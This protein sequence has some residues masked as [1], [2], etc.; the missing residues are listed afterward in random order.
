MPRTT[1]SGLPTSPPAFPA[2]TALP[3]FPSIRSRFVTKPD[4]NTYS[5]WL[6]ECAAD[7]MPNLMVFAGYYEGGRASHLSPVSAEPTRAAGRSDVCHTCH[8][9]FVVIPLAA[10]LA[11]VV[12]QA[13]A[14][15]RHRQQAQQQGGRDVE[16]AQHGDNKRLLDSMQGIARPSGSSEL[17]ERAA[18]CRQRR[19]AALLS[20]KSLHSRGINMVPLHALPGALT[21]H[22]AER[23][24][25]LGRGAA[26]PGGGSEGANSGTLGPAP[27]QP[28]MLDTVSL[29]LEPEE[30]E[31]GPLC[32]VGP[33]HAVL[34]RS[35]RCCVVGKMWCSGAPC[36]P[37]HRCAR[38]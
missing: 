24:G 27:G 15:V 3:A 36:W 21:H 34:I 37:M 23:V 8:Q 30:L 19:L 29:Q 38:C 6:P 32:S 26:W 28:W 14:R 22:L 33:W 11:G 20:R 35:G 25:G 10:V 12:L 9:W 4:G 7:A 1:F 13:L 31:V 2:L 18:L 17:S 16:A 5:R